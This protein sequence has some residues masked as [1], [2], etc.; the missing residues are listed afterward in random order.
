MTGGV[1]DGKLKLWDLTKGRLAFATSVKSASSRHESIVTLVWNAEGTAYAYGHGSHVTVRDVATGSDL[2]DVELPSKVNEICFMEGPQGLFVAAGCNDGSL[3]VLAVPRTVD[4][5]NEILAIMAIEPVDGPV[6]GQERF[7]CLQSAMRYCV[8]T[9]N[10]AGVISLMNLQGAVN[11]ILRDKESAENGSSESDEES[12]SDDD[13]DESESS[14]EEL[15]VE[16]LGSTRLGTGARIT[17]LSVWY[18]QETSKTPEV[19]NDEESSADE[20]NQDGVEAKTTDSRKRR[21]DTRPDTSAFKRRRDDQSTHEVVMDDAALE[22]ARKLVSKAKK[23]Q[24]RKEKRSE[25]T[26][27]KKSKSR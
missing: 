14:E 22:K 23:I 21:T 20:G 11:M 17:C 13:R 24:K 5:T 19:S 26:K 9:A 4:G 18:C 27:K 8:V 25:S 7:K 6:A 12:L 16:I 15:A 1:S 10:S 2:L 3:P